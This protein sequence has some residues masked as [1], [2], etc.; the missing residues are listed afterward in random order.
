[1]DT[2]EIRRA[3]HDLPTPY[4]GVYASDEIPVH[5]A[6]PAAL[7]FNC[8]RKNQPG[9]HWV[10]VY[11]DATGHGTFFDSYGFP[12]IVE[13]HRRRIRENCSFYEWNTRQLQGETS[14]T[15]GHFCLVFLHHM[16]RTS[17]FASFCNI[18][19]D[20]HADNDKIVKRYYERI[21]SNY[22]KR[23]VCNSFMQ[24]C[25]ARRSM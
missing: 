5:W 7:V 10:A 25:R 19:K 24:N 17:D 2:L 11:V 9:S 21:R 18:F 23:D 4:T 8:D 22:V 3:L 15:C 16:S 14:T 12:P 6:R 1:M 20:S 13:E